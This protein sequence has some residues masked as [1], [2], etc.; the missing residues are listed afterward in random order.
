M[1][2]SP[3]READA[4]ADAGSANGALEEK[5][6]LSEHEKK[7]NHIASEQKRRQ[8][9]REGFDRLTELVPGLEGQGRSE[10]VVLKK[11][12]DYMR[13][14]LEERRRLVGRIEEAGGRVEDGMRR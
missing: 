14:Q 9:I 13:A 3:P 10:S 5:P 6:R 4:D 1:S 7:A 8:A 2:T 11:T 12:V